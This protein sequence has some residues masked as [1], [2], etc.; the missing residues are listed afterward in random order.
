MNIERVHEVKVTISQE[1]II[2]LIIDTYVRK[3]PL[4]EIELK[5]S[6]Q[7]LGEYN[8]I[9]TDREEEEDNNFE[10]RYNKETT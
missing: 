5:N 4:E 7:S 8:F 9:V 10:E 6:Y 3:S 2:E 1:E